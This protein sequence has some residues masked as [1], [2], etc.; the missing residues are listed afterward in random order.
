M[1][2]RKTLLL[3]DESP[4]LRERAPLAS[5]LGSFLVALSQN[6][7]RAAVVTV[8]AR[9]EWHDELRRAGTGAYSLR[10]TRYAALPAASWRLASIVRREAPN[11][12]HAFGPFCALISGGSRFLAPGP[13]RIYDRSHVSGG[14]RL[15]Y[16]SRIAA[17]LNDHTMARSEAVRHAALVFD[18]APAEKVSVALDGAPAPREVGAAEITRLKQALGIK[19]GDAVVGIIARLRPEKGHLT[20]L[21]AMRAL[22]PL[23]ERPLHLLIVGAGPFEEVVRQ[24]ISPDEPFIA[25]LIG[26]QEDIAP[27]VAMSDVVAVP[28]YQDASPRTAAEGLAAAR[29]VV[30]SRVGGLP[31]QIVD[32][33]TGILVPPHDPEALT[34]ALLKILT[35]ATLARRLGEAGRSCYLSRFTLEHRSA[36]WIKCY[37]EIMTVN[38]RD[39]PGG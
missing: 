23:L 20:L 19:P 37:D 30:A 27:W 14:P 34:Q 32:G 4:F 7:W 28:S 8:R 31:E 29:P 2:E 26:Y 3:A 9:W 38:L 10:T 33:S 22:G 12:I 25:H 11:I 6:G 36:R 21:E 1:T 39:A 16:G 24:A 5:E 13:V 17:A 18:R 15:T 35:D